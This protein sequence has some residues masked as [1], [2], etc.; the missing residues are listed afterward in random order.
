MSVYTAGHLQDPALLA[1]IGLGNMIQNCIFLAPICGFNSAVETLGSQ[2]VGMGNYALA[3]VYLNRGRVVV[4]IVIC[5][6]LLLSLNT[7]SILL[8]FGQ[9]ETVAGHTHNYIMVYMPAMFIF[10]L[11]DLQRRFLNCFNKNTIPLCAVIISVFIH[12]FWCWYLAITLDMKITGIALAGLICHLTT[13][14]IMSFFFWLDKDVEEACTLP[15]KRALQDL[16]AYMAIGA[17]GVLMLAL[18][19]W[20]YDLMTLTAGSIGVKEQ[21]AQVVTMNM[22]EVCYG[23]GAGVQTACTTL[24]GQKIG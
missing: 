2:A 12:P 8:L 22:S 10:A 16:K 23:V 6:L 7:K 11:S 14:F 5:F 9:D 13:F 17:P 19:L 24:M 4:T 21:A 20:A 15:D 3:G 18:D 1:A